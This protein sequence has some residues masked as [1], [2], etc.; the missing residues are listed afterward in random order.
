MTT[1]ERTMSAVIAVFIVAVASGFFGWQFILNPLN[2]KEVQIAGLQKDIGKR[3]DDLQAVQR[4]KADLERWSRMSLPADTDLS[5]REYWSKL[6]ELFRSSGFD[7]NTTYVV[8]K[9][10][11]SQGAPTYPGPTKKPIYQKVS[12]HVTAEGDMATLVDWMERFYKLPLLHQIRALTITKPTTST[13]AAA[14]GGRGGRGGR[15]EESLHIAMDNE[16]LVLDK[17]EN[18]PALLPDKTDDVPPVIAGALPSSERKYGSIAAKDPF[19]GPLSTSQGPEGTSVD[20]LPFIK[21]DSFTRS[22]N[23]LTVTLRDI[24]NNYDYEI[25]PRTTGGYQVTTS[26]YLPSGKRTLPGRNQKRELEVYDGNTLS[27]HWQIAQVSEKEVIIRS[28]LTNKYYRIQFGQSLEEAIEKALDKT[29]LT[30]LGIKEEPAPTPA[31]DDKD[32][33][34]EKKDGQE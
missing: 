33:K 27:H 13:A 22:G 23:T 1:R 9:G 12:Y 3:L 31:A 5:G 17:A 7:A 25:T 6:N 24:Y 8:P 26:Y 18:R 14:R 32:K 4:R 15:S 21:L 2:A 11:T 34:E 29:E 10:I 16:G 20:L 28:D 19:Y 30:A